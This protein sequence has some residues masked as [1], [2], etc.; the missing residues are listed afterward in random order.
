MS[1]ENNGFESIELQEWRDSIRDVIKIS[2]EDQARKIIEEVDTVALQL[3]VEKYFPLNTSYINTIPPEEQHPFPGSREVERRIKSI[4]R[5]NAMAMVV[6]ANNPGSPKGI[7]GHISTFASAATLYEIGQNHFWR[8]ATDAHPGDLIYFQGH[9]SPGPY[10]RAYLEGRIPVEKLHNFR[11]ELAPGGGLSSY[12]HP[13]L[14][15]DFWQFPTVSMGLGPIGAIYQA[16]FTRYLENRGL[17]EPSDQKI[18]AFLGDGECDE[19]ESL[20]P[21]NLPGREKLD[22]LIFVVNCNLQR[23]DGPVRGNGKIVQELEARFRANNWN[24]IK[25]MWGTDWDELFARDTTG[26]LVKALNE[27]VDGEFQKYSVS[28]GAYIREHFFGRDPDLLKL[29]ENMSDE[30]IVKLRRGGHDPEKVYNA[31]LKATTQANGKPTVILAQTIKGYGLGEV[32]EGKNIAHNHKV[33]NESELKEFRTRFGI[34]ISDDDID[35]DAPFYR[36]AEDSVEMKYLHERRKALGGFVPMRRTKG[37]DFVMPDEKTFHIVDD[38]TGDKEV[39]TTFVLGQ[40]LSRLL[41]D[42]NIGKLVV[43]IIPDEARTFGMES[44]FAQCG[45]YSSSGQLYTPVDA[46]TA[47][48]EKNLMYYKEAKDGQLL[49]EGINEA[50]AMAEFIAAGSAYSSHNLNMIPFYVFYSMFGFQRTGD[51]LWLAGDQRVKGFVCG[52]TAGRTSLNGEGLQHEDGHSHVIALS[53][54]NCV[55]YDPAFGFELGVILKDGIRRMYLENEDVY[56]YITLMNDEYIQQPKPAGDHIDEGILKG[57][58]KFRPSPLEG[59]V[60]TNILGSGAILNS[61]LEAQKILAENYGV[62][63]DV[64]SVTSYKYLQE[65]CNDTARWN[66]MHPAETPKK[67]YVETLFEGGPDLF[68]ATSDYMKILPEAL[69]RWLPGSLIS[70]GTN[71]YGRSESRPALR[72]FFEVDARYTAFATLTGLANT[73]RVDREVLIQAMTDLDIDPEKPNPMY[74]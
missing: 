49:Q 61:A 24:V 47:N 55:A 10:S 71:G 46:I 27:T 12:P 38:G 31:Y 33:M 53:V 52:G 58:Y 7:G 74:C 43:P 60:H 73:G 67:S 13:W 42:K 72:D 4:I 2:G 69:S 36:P 26:K 32:G 20:A 54:P 40:M 66:M 59:E 25:V 57:C 41:K 16:R 64:Y 11:R 50:G 5:W 1:T 6:N 21:I 14:M 44:L 45:I 48:G 37:P 8:G 56:Y 30:E 9:A 35:H 23:L 39:S 63:A 19:P 18:W 51:Q 70:L 62:S 15:P 34:P 28:N 68:V 17:K 29:V 3:G 65:D 22:N